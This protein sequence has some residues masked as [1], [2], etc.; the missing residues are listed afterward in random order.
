LES[1]SSGYRL[2]AV[3][4]HRISLEPA[5]EVEGTPD[6]QEVYF[7]WD[8]R[9][10]GE[11]V[12][13]VRVSVKVSASKSVRQTL[14][15]DL[16]GRFEIVGDRQSLELKSFAMISATAILLPYLREL[17]ASVS[18]RSHFGA[19][20]LPIFNVPVLMEGMSW[21]RSTAGQQLRERKSNAVEQPFE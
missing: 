21:E 9:L 17:V 12:L 16:M 18:G 2:K 13:D 10:V 11:D 19:H 14:A 1:I 7:S 15:V 6:E 4:A 3:E 20:H 5:A 8:C